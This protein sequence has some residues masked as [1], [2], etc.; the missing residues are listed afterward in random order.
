MTAHA[1]SVVTGQASVATWHI[2]LETGN[3]FPVHSGQESR[4]P[5]ST[6]H[7]DDKHM[8]VSMVRVSDQRTLFIQLIPLKFIV[9]Q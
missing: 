9:M 5:V 4:I 6:L 7:K 8:F 1:W 3:L 2:P